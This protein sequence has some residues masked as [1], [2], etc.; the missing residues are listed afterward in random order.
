MSDVPDCVFPSSSYEGF[1]DLDY[2]LQGDVF[3]YPMV[4]GSQARTK[5]YQGRTIILG[6][7]RLQVIHRRL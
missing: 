6:R 3:D 1:A 5:S 2:S 7:M 4:W